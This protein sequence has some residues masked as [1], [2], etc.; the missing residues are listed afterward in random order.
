MFVLILTTRKVI[1]LSRNL[2]FSELP[3]AMW[4]KAPSNPGGECLAGPCAHHSTLSR[5]AIWQ[6]YTEKLFR[7]AQLE[8]SVNLC[9]QTSERLSDLGGKWPHGDLK[10]DPKKN[11]Q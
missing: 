5:E 3:S 11:F 2:A 10:L 8:T 4:V 6:M 7:T 1:L 9:L